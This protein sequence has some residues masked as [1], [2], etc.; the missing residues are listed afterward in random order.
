M[1][2][3]SFGSSESFENNRVR[4]QGNLEKLNAVSVSVLDS[5]EGR[6]EIKSLQERISKK[7]SDYKDRV[8]DKMS[9]ISDSEV[10]PKVMLAAL[11][12]PVLTTVAQSLRS[13]Y[14]EWGAALD[15]A[16]EALQYIIHL[17]IWASVTEFVGWKNGGIEINNLLAD[18]SSGKEALSAL[19]ADQ[20]SVLTSNLST[21]EMN[22]LQNVSGTE[23]Y[24]GALAESATVA[25]GLGNMG[26]VLVAGGVV[27]MAQR[28]LEKLV[29]RYK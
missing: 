21:E 27:M 12:L 10:V 16:P 26:A 14:P 8:L 18:I 19:S 13:H 15:S 6:D 23:T 2:A 4:L 25:K 17:D 1:S 9:S 11:S 7:F 20:M 22:A 5:P 24:A 28:S 3:E 29:E